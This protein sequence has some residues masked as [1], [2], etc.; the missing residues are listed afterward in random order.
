MT[1]KDALNKLIAGNKRYLEGNL[2]HPHQTQKRRGD[3]ASGQEPFAC[4]LSCADSR[5]PPEIVFDQGLGDLFVLRVA[6]NVVNDMIVGSLEYAVEHLGAPLIVVLG[7]KRC[8]AVSATV[9]G[10][11]VPGKIGCLVQA[12]QPAV[13]AVKG[14]TGDPVDSAAIENI[15]RGVEKLKA[16]APILSEKVNAGQLQIAGAFYDLDTGE[17]ILIKN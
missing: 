17:V 2:E 3:L 6:G 10:G 14:Q 8:G 1:G 13:D 15:K 7:H 5:V 4:V 12:I 16:A 11:E 9:Q